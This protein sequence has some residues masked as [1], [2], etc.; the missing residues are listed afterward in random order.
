ML[1]INRLL[2]PFLSLSGTPNQ[3]KQQ[4]ITYH[5]N[6]LLPPCCVDNTRITAYTLRYIPCTH[7]STRSSKR[8]QHT[9]FGLVCSPT[10]TPLSTSTPPSIEWSR[11]IIALCTTTHTPSV[12]MALTAR[13]NRKSSIRL[14]GRVLSGN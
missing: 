8:P 1:R 13:G 3:T 4:I 2:G 11:M 9:R 5:R 7:I 14:P 12:S 10:K 6:P